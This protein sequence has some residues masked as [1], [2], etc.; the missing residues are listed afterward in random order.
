MAIDAPAP[1]VKLL[2][3]NES[4]PLLRVNTPEALMLALLLKLTPELLLI[5]KNAK[6][7]VPV[8]LMVCAAEPFMNNALLLGVKVPLLTKL[9][10]T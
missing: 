2:V 1:N 8:P 6:A 9:P 7:K 10:A 5:N 4:N 3:P